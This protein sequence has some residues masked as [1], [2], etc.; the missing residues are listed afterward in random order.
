MLL[1]EDEDV[2]EELEDEVV[3]LLLEDTVADDEVT[4]ALELVAAPPVPEAVLDVLGPEVLLDEVA[5]PLPEDPA[6]GGMHWAFS[7]QE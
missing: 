1:D 6:L 4:L 3:A 7:S 5:P 2:E